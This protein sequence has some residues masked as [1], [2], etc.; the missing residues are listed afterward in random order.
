MA[1]LPG[2]L[3]HPPAPL[4]QRSRGQQP[5][6]GLPRETLGNGHRHREM[7]VGEDTVADPG[8][9]SAAYRIAACPPIDQPCN[10]TWLAR[11]PTSAP[12]RTMRSE[13]I[14]R[15]VRSERRFAE[16]RSRQVGSDQ[17]PRS[18]SGFDRPG[19]GLRGHRRRS[20]P[21][22]AG[23]ISQVPRQRARTASGAEP[24]LDAKAEESAP[25]WS[26]YIVVGLVTTAVAARIVLAI[27]WTRRPDADTMTQRDRD[28]LQL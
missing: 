21:G 14:C 22:S 10:T 28:R 12:G 5:G 3:Q 18:A 25:P 13:P 9:K 2:A 26:L 7:H 4:G 8:R 24:A 19:S 20:V 1:E 6:Q 23:R 15:R 11:V 17:R 27:I 16:H